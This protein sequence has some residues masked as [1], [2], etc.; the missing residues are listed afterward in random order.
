M[1]ILLTVAYDGTNYSG[2][3]R[4][5]NA[6]TVQEKIEDALQILL[7]RPV[8]LRASSRTDAGVHALGQRTSFFAPDLL[9]PVNKLPMVLV[10]LLPPDISIINAEVVSNDF[11]PRFDAKHKTYAYNIYSANT[12]NPLTRRYS[13]FVPSK[14]NINNMQ[15]AAQKFIGQ[16]DFAAFCATGSSAKTT[17]REVFNCTVDKNMEKMPANCYTLTITGN[18]FLY[19]MVRII[20]GTILYVGMGKITPNEIEK[21]I[22][23]KDR[24]NAGKTMPAEGLV[25]LEVVYD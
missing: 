14:L 15:K 20:A 8:T 1:Q 12:P 10:G 18:G 22:L 13:A 23:S 24:K 9:V 19:N 21:I 16:H 7:K 6:I 25:L 4:Q 11:N 3:Q 5:D 2:W 17:V